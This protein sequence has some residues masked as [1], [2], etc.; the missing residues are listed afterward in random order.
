[1]P[2][3]LLVVDAL[4]VALAMPQDARLLLRSKRSL[5]CA[6]K[7]AASLSAV[8]LKRW[9]VIACKRMRAIAAT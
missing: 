8:M 3:N 5:Q 1:M 4:A 2:D 7:P 9:S 6:I